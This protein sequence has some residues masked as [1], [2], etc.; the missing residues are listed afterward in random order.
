MLEVSPDTVPL[1]ML[2]HLGSFSL[3]HALREAISHKFDEPSRLEMHKQS[4][5][6]LE[7][8]SKLDRRACSLDKTSSLPRHVS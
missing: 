7:S 4:T 6:Y 2:V 8:H 1:S 5:P 3:S